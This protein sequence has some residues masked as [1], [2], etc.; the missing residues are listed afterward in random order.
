MLRNPALT[1]A[2][3]ETSS[4]KSAVFPLPTVFPS[5]TPWTCAA[6]WSHLQ[7]NNTVCL[8]KIAWIKNKTNN[9]VIKTSCW[10]KIRMTDLH[11]SVVWSVEKTNTAHSNR[12]WVSRSPERT[13]WPQDV[14]NGC[15]DW[16]INVQ[17]CWTTSLTYLHGRRHFCLFI[18]GHS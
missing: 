4:L 6:Y 3:S 1:I 18:G 5:S 2:L 13:T 7:F 12:E 15:V 17:N 9:W 8:I 14:Y 16:V 11:T 10:T